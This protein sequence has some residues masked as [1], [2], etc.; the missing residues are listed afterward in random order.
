M[1]GFFQV[2]SLSA[3][4]KETARKEMPSPLAFA[5]YIYMYAG[6]LT[7]PQ[8]CN[9]YAH[10]AIRC[11][12][13]LW[14][15]FFFFARLLQ[16]FIWVFSTYCIIVFDEAIRRFCSGCLLRPGHRRSSSMVRR[17]ASGLQA[18]SNL[19]NLIFSTLHRFT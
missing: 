6:F 2:E 18:A 8:V 15:E 14:K 5:G 1:D 17:F 11:V 10:V 16:W 3:E 19:Q 4:Q 12:V 7:G 9:V 13:C